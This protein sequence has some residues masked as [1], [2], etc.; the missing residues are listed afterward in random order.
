MAKGKERPMHFHNHK[1]RVGDA[2]IKGRGVFAKCAIKRGEAIESAPTLVIPARDIEALSGTFLSNY[3]FAHNDDFELLA[4]GYASL[5]NHSFEP[6]AQFVIMKKAIL[7]V[8]TRA[9]AEGEEITF[10][11]G[12]PTESFRA[13][14]IEVPA[15][16]T[17]L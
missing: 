16:Y 11:Y 4:L 15:N 6:N 9:I 12:W 7:L 8:A 14:G 10:E 5:Y 2:G 3:S 17:G 1:V 13:A